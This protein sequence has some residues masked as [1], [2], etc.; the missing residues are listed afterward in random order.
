MRTWGLIVATVVALTP[1]AWT[2]VAA[3][4]STVQVTHSEA[5]V[6]GPM[7]I[8]VSG[9]ADAA[10][11]LHVT[12]H[13][14]G[15][16]C[17]WPLRDPDRLTPSGTG[18]TIA[19]GDFTR[20]YDYTPQ[21]AGFN[22]VYRV[23]A[24][25]AQGDISA[26]SLEA[27]GEATFVPRDAVLSAAVSGVTDIAPS[28]P[29]SVTVSGRIEVPRTLHVRTGEERSTCAEQGAPAGSPTRDGVALTPVE[30]I[31]LGAGDYSRQFAWTPQPDPRRVRPGRICVWL[32]SQGA[33]SDRRS[34]DFA[35]TY[36]LPPRR[37]E[38]DEIP[39]P[40]I[41]PAD[42]AGGTLLNPVFAW[43]KEAADLWD[44]QRDALEL[45]LVDGTRTT[46]LLRLDREGYSVRSDV[47]GRLLG[48]KGRG[49][50]PDIA[51]LSDET[52]SGEERI[53]LREGFAPGTYQWRVVSAEQAP[54]VPRRFTV[55][56]VPIGEIAVRSE[57]NRGRFSSRPGW[58]AFTLQ[59][60]TFARHRFEYRRRGGS[61][62]QVRWSTRRDAKSVTYVNWS[63]VRP[64]GAIEWRAHVTD[65]FGTKR[66][67]RGRIANV[68]VARC[69]ALRRRE[70]AKRRHDAARRRAQERRRAARE[71]RR[72]A[73]EVRRFQSNCRGVGGTPVLLDDGAGWSWYCRAPWGG[74]LDVPGF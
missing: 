68:S 73:A 11:G 57:R 71:R 40:V 55:T 47:A 8:T 2:G 54:S 12:V 42:G 29:T 39:F 34:F 50:T 48:V 33:V 37:L 44:E 64:G 28:A 21:L 5:I 65:W 18:D 62:K 7:T 51:T 23:C 19:A 49:A 53:R 59:A 22:T 20:T 1:V 17:D 26:R 36:R 35:V 6:Y 30:G 45:A 69:A 43:S 60:A 32:L 74:L 15:K 4:A 67:K 3:G 63:C 66:T 41:A 27:S 9:H 10:T 56:G 38:P 72:E 70:A 13:N 46:P 52:P 31:P 24:W 16:A 14:D 58:T 61:W 25:V